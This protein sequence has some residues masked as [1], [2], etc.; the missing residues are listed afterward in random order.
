MSY[1]IAINNQF[2][3]L[4]VSFTEKPTEAIREALKSLKFR[5]NPKKSVWYGFTEKETLEK[6]LSGEK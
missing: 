1:S 6:V 3:S 5:W 2:N 4:E